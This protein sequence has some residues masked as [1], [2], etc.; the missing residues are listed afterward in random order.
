MAVGNKNHHA[1]A[2]VTAMPERTTVYTT[3]VGLIN[4]TDDKVGGEVSTPAPLLPA[5]A[6]PFA[7]RR[8]PQP[9]AAVYAPLFVPLAAFLPAAF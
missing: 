6:R 7:R 8:K 1:L 9:S 2:S 5:T 4:A 3:L